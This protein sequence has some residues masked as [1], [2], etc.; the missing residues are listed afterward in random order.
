MVLSVGPS[1][2][3]L[4][5]K[6]SVAVHSATE[7]HLGYRTID[8]IASL[9][10]RKS[11]VEA[12]LRIGPM[13]ATQSSSSNEKVYPAKTVATVALGSL[14]GS[15]LLVFGGGLLLFRSRTQPSVTT[16][17]PLPALNPNRAI[18][19]TAD[20][21]AGPAT[22]NP[23]PNSP[24]SNPNAVGPSNGTDPTNP[25]PS[26]PGAPSGGSATIGSISIS[27]CF[28]AGP[29][30]PIPGANCGALPA[31]QQ[32]LATKAT[33]IGD[34]A[35][36]SHG[37]LALV[38]DFRFSTSFARGWGS[39]A[40]NVPRAGDVAGCVKQAILPLPYATLAHDHDRYYTTIPIDF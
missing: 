14:V 34:C 4:L 12:H 15:F 40:S 17:A 26:P 38:L 25:T 31:L 8:L 18:A 20:P 5:E 29:P 22:E 10:L 16:G 32:Y 11:T 9:A 37:R 33:Q 35:H 1:R 6:Y 30:T 23:T 19:L 13:A 3:S 39:P 24:D 2:F 21:D 36:E 7:Q 28:D 27:R